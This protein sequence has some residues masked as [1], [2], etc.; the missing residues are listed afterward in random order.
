MKSSAISFMLLVGILVAGAYS[1]RSLLDVV[2]V[3]PLGASIDPMVAANKATPVHLPELNAL[4]ETRERPLFQ[5]GRRPVENRPDD[6][7]EDDIRG[8]TLV[9]LMGHNSRKARALIRIDGEPDAK[10]V[11]AD[12]MVGAY[13]VTQITGRS[14]VLESNGR[15]FELHMLPRTTPLEDP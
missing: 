4:R 10:W 13:Q 2:D 8:V 5:P 6:E 15:S 14:L 11:A 3:S 1:V 7:A 9:G 12:D